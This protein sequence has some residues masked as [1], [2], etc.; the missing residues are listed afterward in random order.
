MRDNDDV[1]VKI[2][3]IAQTRLSVNRSDATPAAV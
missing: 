2:H 3:K 1:R